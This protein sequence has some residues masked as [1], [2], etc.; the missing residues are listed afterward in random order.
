ML[1]VERA[2]LTCTYVKTNVEKYTSDKDAIKSYVKLKESSNYA[3]DFK[4]NKP[5][6]IWPLFRKVDIEH[7][8]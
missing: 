3:A 1:F 4:Y 6:E 7:K 2:T 8:K 5:E